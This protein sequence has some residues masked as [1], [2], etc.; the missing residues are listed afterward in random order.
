MRSR[1]PQRSAAERVYNQLVPIFLT[2]HPWCESPWPCGEAATEVQHRHGR[3]GWRLLD[4]EWWAPS[5]HECNM[6]AETDTGAA[7]DLR[8]LVPEGFEGLPSELPILQAV[9]AAS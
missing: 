5:C 8:W 2:R 1:T 7:L 9:E 4:M 3:H 6:R